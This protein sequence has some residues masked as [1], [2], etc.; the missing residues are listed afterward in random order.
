MVELGIFFWDHVL[1]QTSKGQ[2][3]REDAVGVWCSIHTQNA[4]MI[5]APSKHFMRLCLH[6]QI[7]FFA[8]RDTKSQ[9]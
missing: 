9:I 6:I 3:L 7:S 8:Q 2:V 1:R 4:E 5:F